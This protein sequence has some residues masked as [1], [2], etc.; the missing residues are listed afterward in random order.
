MLDWFDRPYHSVYSFSSESQFMKI[1]PQI[2]ALS[3]SF[4]LVHYF[5]ET[6]ISF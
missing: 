6:L 3:N 2:L 4:Y 5:R 1:Q